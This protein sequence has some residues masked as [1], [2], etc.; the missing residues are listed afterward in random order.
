VVPKLI[1][2]KTLV[3]GIPGPSVAPMLSPFK[4]PASRAPAPLY[5]PN[6][7]AKRDRPEPSE[8]SGVGPEAKRFS[9]ATKADDDDVPE[10][11]W[12]HRALKVDQVPTN[13]ERRAMLLMRLFLLRHWRKITTRSLLNVLDLRPSQY[14]EVK[15]AESHYSWLPS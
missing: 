12:D 2:F 4:A 6:I 5:F 13:K 9:L 14:V 15:R 7:A 1:S 11:L 8:V 3:S 10:H